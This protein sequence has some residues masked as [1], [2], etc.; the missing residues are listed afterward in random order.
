MNTARGAL[1]GA[2]DAATALSF[3]GLIGAST[4]ALTERYEG[5]GDSWV[6]KSSLNTSR[7]YLKGSSSGSSSNTLSF[8]GG[9]GGGAATPSAVTELYD[10]EG[11]SWTTRTSMSTA[12]FGIGG[13]GDSSSALAF[14]GSTGSNSAV[15]ESFASTVA[16][17]TFT[18]T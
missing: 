1:G 6:S 12:R 5:V 13:S 14:G 11:D 8:G 18:T 15:T 10:V 16:E 7:A 17:V 3:G 2:D 4:S 9:T